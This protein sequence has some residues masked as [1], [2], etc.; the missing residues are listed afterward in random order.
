MQHAKDS[1]YVA[2][3]DRLAALAPAR[4]ITLG[5]VTRPAVIV[6]ENEPL[7][8]AAPQPCAFYLRWGAARI[9]SATRASR[10][11]LL[12]I[13]CLISYCT[14]GDP[15]LQGVDRGRA[16]AALDL[17]L[18]RI[19]SPCEAAKCDHSQSPPADLGTRLHWTMP[20]LLPLSGGSGN[21]PTL[22]LEDGELRFSPSAPAAY[23]E[24]RARLTLFFFP[25]VDLK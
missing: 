2:L 15:D 25:E 9:V 13:E 6:E 21:A 19:C 22:A 20:E 17:E 24:R 4:T 16:L 11:P 5:G 18:L 23:L 8:A 12:G 3:R 14:P 1:F 10:R 7:T